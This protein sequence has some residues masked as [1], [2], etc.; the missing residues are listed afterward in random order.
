MVK[1]LDVIPEESPSQVQESSLVKKMMRLHMESPYSPQNTHIH[2]SN[3]VAKKLTLGYR[4]TPVIEDFNE[5]KLSSATQLTSYN[6]DRLE[7]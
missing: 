6:V 1:A 4:L 5:M 2:T 3:Q 7:S